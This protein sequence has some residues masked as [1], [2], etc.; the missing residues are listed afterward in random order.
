MCWLIVSTGEGHVSRQCGTCGVRREGTANIN[1]M[2]AYLDELV[3]LVVNQVDMGLPVSRTPDGENAYIHK[4][5]RPL[6]TMNIYLSMLDLTAHL[7]VSS[8]SYT[9]L[10]R[11]RQGQAQNLI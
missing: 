2:M 3:V 6:V 7:V 11:R 5:T 4:M 10:V 9:N 8:A 1:M